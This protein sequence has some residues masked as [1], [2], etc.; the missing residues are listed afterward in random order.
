MFTID[1]VLASFVPISLDKMDEVKLLDRMDTKYVFRAGALPRIILQLRPFYYILDINNVRL[2]KYETLYFDTPGYQLYLD[3]HNKRLN[4]FKVRS[5]RYLDSDLSYFEIKFKNNK[6]RTFKKR[7]KLKEP[8]GIITGKQEK[9]LQSS[10]GF[11]TEMLRPAIRIYFS[12]ITLVNIG[13]TERI[14]FDTGLTFSNESST[15]SY[16]GIV[17]AEVKQ[18]RSSGSFCS[19]VLHQ[20]HIIPQKISKYCLGVISLNKQIKK[21]NFKEKL[22]IINKLN[23]DL[24]ETNHPV[25]PPVAAG[26]AG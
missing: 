13:M 10:T 7:N 24:S 15:C 4:R 9:L 21:N 26:F 2:Q 6:D 8:L 5:R 22:H 20:E 3:H 14:T 17:I 11:T 12:R 1:E 19:K 25:L 23:H 16:P 18:N